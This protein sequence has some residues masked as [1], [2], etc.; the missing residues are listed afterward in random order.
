M[1]ASDRHKHNPIPFRPQAPDREWLAAYA[2][3]TGLAVNAI[4]TAALRLLRERAEK[5]N[6]AGEPGE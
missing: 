4:L 1:R 6:G 5:N 2:E 3:K